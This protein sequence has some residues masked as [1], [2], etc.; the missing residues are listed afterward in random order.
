M[1]SDG[2][3]YVPVP[4]VSAIVPGSIVNKFNPRGE[5][6]EEWVEQMEKQNEYAD[7][8]PIEDKEWAS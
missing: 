2:S 5:D 6:A 8:E 4:D 3:V 7:H 1:V